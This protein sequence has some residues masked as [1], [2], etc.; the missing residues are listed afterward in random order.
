MAAYGEIP[1][2][3]DI[4]YEGRAVARNFAWMRPEDLVFT[5]VVNGWLLGEDPPAVDVLAWNNDPSSLS[6]RFDAELLDLF[7][8]NALAEPGA[9]RVLGT[10]VDLGTV[11]CDSYLV[12]GMTDHIAPWRACYLTSQ[13]VA[14][15]CEVVLTPTGHIHSVVNPPGRPKARYFT[16]AEPGP[17]PDAWLAKATEHQGSWWPHWVEWLVARSGAERAAPEKLG[18]PRYPAGDPAPGC[19]V[20]E[21]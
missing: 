3:V 10:A 15:R 7:V 16:G 21:R 18:S 14:G 17:D 11:T 8:G 9:F 19:Y 20:Y 13:L 4:V 6:A 5:Y 1:M 2:T 12:A